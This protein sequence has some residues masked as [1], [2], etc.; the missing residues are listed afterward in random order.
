MLVLNCS[1]SSVSLADQ[2]QNLNQIYAEIEKSRGLSFKYQ[3]PCS[4]KSK[5]E[6]LIY[7]ISAFKKQLPESKLHYEEILLKSLNLIPQNYN[8]KDNLLKLYKDQVA[9]YYDPFEKSYTI[10]SW[11]PSF[12][13]ASV[14]MHELTH[15]LQ[16]QNFNLLTFSTPEMTTDQSLARSAVIEGDATYTMLELSRIATGQSSLSS[17]HDISQLSRTITE[18]SKNSESFN[19]SPDILKAITLFPYTGGLNFIFKFKK[20]YK[21]K[22]NNDY[23]KNP[24]NYT[25][26]IL[27]P[28]ELANN[29][30]PKSLQCPEIENLSLLE[31]D[32]LGEYFFSLLV[33]ENFNTRGWN[34]DQVCVYGNKESKKIELIRIESNWIEEKQF[35]VVREYFEKM[36]K[37]KLTKAKLPELVVETS[38]K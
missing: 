10:A 17:I 19:R 5:E 1:L 12:M 16:D 14:A 28:D 21:D 35:L 31:K 13:H 24:P 2:C 30:T 9:G 3:V 18:N 36:K 22:D 37:Y 7:L 26:Q 33:K 32:S 20:L 29:L 15:V 4:E 6:V 23:F 8:Y 34:G 27:H 38:V 25:S 11:I